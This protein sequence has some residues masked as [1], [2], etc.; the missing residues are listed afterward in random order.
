MI[1]ISSLLL[2]FSSSFVFADYYVLTQ[3]KANNS[4]R[5]GIMLEVKTIYHVV[6]AFLEPSA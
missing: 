3:L 5:K 6:S 2:N 1:C 4:V